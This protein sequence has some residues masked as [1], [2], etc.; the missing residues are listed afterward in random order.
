[1]NRLVFSI[2]LL[3]FVLSGCGFGGFDLS[4]I[5]GGLFKA[6]PEVPEIPVERVDWQDYSDEI[7]EILPYEHHGCMLL[8]VKHELSCGECDVMDKTF[9]HPQVVSILNNNKFIA[10]KA[11]DDMEDFEKAV[12][13]TRSKMTPTI[14]ITTMGTTLEPLFYHEESAIPPRAFIGILE[15]ASVKCQLQ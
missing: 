14:S 4:N 1:M 9:N 6:R 3:C 7:V 13:R 5:R 12:Y 15:E 11:T 8:Y 10:I 2:F